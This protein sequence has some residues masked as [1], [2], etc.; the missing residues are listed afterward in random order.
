MHVPATDM[1]GGYSVL[2]G[3]WPVRKC[4]ITKSD[5]DPDVGWIRLPVQ[6][7]RDHVL[8]NLSP[9]KMQVL[10]MEYPI[11][12]SVVNNDIGE[13][14]VQDRI[15]IQKAQLFIYACMLRE[16]RPLVTEGTL[17]A[18]QEVKIRWVAGDDGGE[19]GTYFISLFYHNY[20]YS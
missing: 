17:M 11:L 15:H 12:I 16:T 3:H 4:I 7:V 1:E 14:Y 19:G 9:E 5:A 8:P 13:S 10:E 2:N 6:L 18:G 20:I